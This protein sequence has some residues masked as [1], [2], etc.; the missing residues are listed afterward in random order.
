[1][2]RPR[3]ILAALLLLSAAVAGCDSGPKVVRV[4][5]TATREGKPVAGLL[6]NFEPEKGRS[7]WGISDD[8]GRFTMEYDAEQKGVVAGRHTVS[9]VFRADELAGTKPTPATRAIQA[10][11]GDLTKSP[12]KIEVTA[13]TEALELKFD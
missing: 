6:I 10:K 13:A 2:P 3:L 1:M 11:Y 9:A 4:S 5:G 8:A 7:S 12:M